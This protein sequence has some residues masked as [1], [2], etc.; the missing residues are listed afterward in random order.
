MENRNLGFVLVALSIAMFLLISSFT[1]EINES[2]SSSCTS[3]SMPGGTCPHE[4]N[5]PWQSYIGFTV[6]FIVLIAG[7]YI[8]L[9]GS[10]ARLAKLK[11]RKE[12][13]ELV[14]TLKPDEKKVFEALADSDGVLFQSELVEKTGF[15][16]VK[17]TRVLDKLEG[18]NILERKRRG[19][20]NVVVLK[21]RE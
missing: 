18:L 11:V 16:K 5:L 14:K 1:I 10:R 20:S 8:M 2:M 12:A 17:V 21:H 9:Q 13:Q 19:M 6:S 3:C 7:F 15:K 4:G